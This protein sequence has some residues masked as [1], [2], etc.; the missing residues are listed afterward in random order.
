MPRERQEV[1]KDLLGANQSIQ[2]SL[3]ALRELRKAQGPAEEK[4]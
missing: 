4:S 2:I 1:L 3:D